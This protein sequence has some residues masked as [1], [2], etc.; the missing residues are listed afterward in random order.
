MNSGKTAVAAKVAVDSGFPFVRMISADEMIGYSDTSK[1]QI[2]HKAFLDSYKSPLSLIFID[3]IER[4]IE[5]VPI[6][7]RFS[8]TVLQ[9]LLVLLKKVPP[10]QGRRLL[11][12]GTTSCPHLLEDLGL[13]QAFSLTQSVPL[14]EEPSQITEVLRMAGHMNEQDARSIARA[15]TKP[16]GIKHL[17]MVAEM[18]RQGS[19]GDTVDTNVFMECLHTVGY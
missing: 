9:T 1:S 11:V 19:D 14:L 15:I 8:N 2:I 17:L 16:I 13:T 5:Y 3:D 6:G 10:D 7:P 18:A 4:I 12:I